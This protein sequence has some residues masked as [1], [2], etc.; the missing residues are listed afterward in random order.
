MK[1]KEHPREQD[2]SPTTRQTHGDKRSR[3]QDGRP[4]S[5]GEDPESTIVIHG[6]NQPGPS[7][8]QPLQYG[9][10][11]PI[12]ASQQFPLLSQVPTMLSG[13]S[14]VP[15]EF[16]APS[17]HP[18]MTIPSLPILRHPS[19]NA[20]AISTPPISSHAV[21]G[22]LP[23]P[24]SVPRGPS[25]VPGVLTQISSIPQG[26]SMGLDA[27]V[28]YQAQMLSHATA[29]VQAM[30]QV[31]LAAQAQAQAQ[32]QA[33]SQTVLQQQLLSQQQAQL[34]SQQQTHVLVQQQQQLIQG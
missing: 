18:G 17:V 28:A 22:L 8:V 34:I 6:G 19:N 5:P 31:Q 27:T 12:Q 23:P 33:Q 7:R 4:G 25:A 32:L 16:S 14:G 21:P 26:T 9:T 11:F 10:Q 29:S 3:T 30:A 1:R 20:G 15:F 24:S 13:V 2:T